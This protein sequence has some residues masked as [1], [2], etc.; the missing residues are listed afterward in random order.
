[1]F[2][3]LSRINQ[4]AC[5]LSCCLLIALSGCNSS[6]RTS[7]PEKA[8]PPTVSQLST[9]QLSLDDRIE[10]IEQYVAFRRSYL[11]LDY[12]IRYQNN[13]EGF[14]PGPSDWDIK[15]LAVIPRSDI[16]EWVSPQAQRIEREPPEWLGNM[17]GA[18]STEGINEWYSDG[19]SVIGIDRYKAII[20]FW[21]TTF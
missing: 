5:L 16:D 7:E 18:I 11:E 10:F 9:E 15:I 2:P 8:G 6:L 13:G 14:V 19:N 21:N 3:P 12:D 4:I 20:L 1:M 17:P